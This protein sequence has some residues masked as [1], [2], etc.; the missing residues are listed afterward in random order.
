MVRLRRRSGL[1]GLRARNDRSARDGAALGHERAS[2]KHCAVFNP[3]VSGDFDPT[4][5]AFVVYDA[6]GTKSRK[7]AD[8]HTTVGTHRRPAFDDRSLSD[9]ER[10]PTV[11]EKLDWSGRRNQNDTAPN[12]KLAIARDARPAKDPHP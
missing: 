11:S 8:R 5:S 7:S 4:R 9:P 10:C 2:E 6:A 3:S 1:D 12:G